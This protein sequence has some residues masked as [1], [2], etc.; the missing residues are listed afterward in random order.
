MVLAPFNTPYHSQSHFY[1]LFHFTALNSIQLEWQRIR[2]LNFHCIT[3]LCVWHVTFH[4]HLPSNGEKWSA[5]SVTF[6]HIPHTAQFLQKRPGQLQPTKCFYKY[7]TKMASVLLFPYYNGS[8]H[9]H[10]PQYISNNPQYITIII[11]IFLFC[12]CLSTM[13]YFNFVAGSTSMPWI[14]DGSNQTRGYTPPK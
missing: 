2:K 12:F 6:A 13:I 11:H 9:F 4:F 14:I 1:Q 7:S 5:N 3:Q 10:H 8:F